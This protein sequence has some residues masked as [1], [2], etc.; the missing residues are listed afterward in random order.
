MQ[1]DQYYQSSTGGLSAQNWLWKFVSA[2]ALS[3][4]VIFAFCAASLQVDG[5][6]ETYM[7]ED[8]AA[9]MIGALVFAAAALLSALAA[10]RGVGLL[11]VFTS[12]LCTAAFL[13]EMSFGE[14]HIGF[15]APVVGGTKIDALHDIL[16]LSWNAVEHD[17]LYLIYA[18]IFSAAMVSFG[19]YLFRKSAAF[20]SLVSSRAMPVIVASITLIAVAQVVDY[21][22]GTK[23]ILTVFGETGL[24]VLNRSSFEEAAECVASFLL[25]AAAAQLVSMSRT[26]N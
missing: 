24:E 15:A 25:L 22:F 7:Q 16:A 17:K 20:R 14:R 8:Q 10:F 5:F 1:N 11:A 3:S 6:A 9:E 26:A 4:I 21:P 13:D 2:L 12:L 18:V 19:M 23:I